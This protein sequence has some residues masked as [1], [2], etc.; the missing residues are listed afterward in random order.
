MEKMQENRQGWRFYVA[1]SC[2]DLNA[3]WFQQ[4]SYLPPDSV[5]TM[6]PSYIAHTGSR[7]CSPQQSCL[8]VNTSSAPSA[9]PWV[10]KARPQT[11]F[12]HL[13]MLLFVTMATQYNMNI[14]KWTGSS[15]NHMSRGNELKNSS[16]SSWCGQQVYIH[17]WPATYGQ[18]K[19]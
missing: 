19:K 12:I 17:S 15:P 8:K 9:D 18:I 4:I 7:S 3:K 11:T 1:L 10:W 16:K 5:P 6:P 13:I 14:T 2:S